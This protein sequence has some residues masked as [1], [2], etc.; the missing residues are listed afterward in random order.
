MACAA[1]PWMLAASPWMTPR[2]PARV[3]GSSESKTWSRLTNEYVWSSPIVPAV[4][5]SGASRRG[6]LEHH[7]PGGDP[8]QRVL[9]DPR[10]RAL[11]QRRRARVDR[12]RDLRL[13]VG[14]E[15]DRLDRP[16][17]RRPHQHV[18]AGDEA[19]GVL[20]LGVQ[21]VRRAP[22]QHHQDHDDDRD[23][24]RGD[25]GDPRDHESFNIRVGIRAVVAEDMVAR[26][27][28]PLP[29]DSAGGAPILP[30]TGS[31]CQGRMFRRC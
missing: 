17:L 31:D 14:R 3:S 30:E 9:V 25:R 13:A 4:G 21:R 26:L 11:V 12:H 24:Q 2:S 16:D 15:R 10:H 7:V 29:R 27:S 1:R 28:P 18:V 20:E 22:A 19:A 8:R 5:I 6:R 23:R